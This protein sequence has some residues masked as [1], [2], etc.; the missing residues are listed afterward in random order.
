M[1][2]NYLNDYLT[3]LGD[4]VSKRKQSVDQVKLESHD[5]NVSTATNQLTLPSSVSV[6]IREDSEVVYECGI[7]WGKLADS[8]APS[9]WSKIKA[10]FVGQ[11]KAVR[12]MCSH[13]YHLSCLETW[14][15]KKKECPMC[16]KEIACR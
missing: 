2:L 15:A 6:E 7:C 13:S 8:K 4:S 3:D 16:R 1:R 11:K 12:T 14:V 10:E 9:A 5:T